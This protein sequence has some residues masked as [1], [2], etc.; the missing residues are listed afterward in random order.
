MAKITLAYLYASNMNRDGILSVSILLC[1][2]DYD[3]IT[4]ENFILAPPSTW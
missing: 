3:S 2:Y 4:F 1:A